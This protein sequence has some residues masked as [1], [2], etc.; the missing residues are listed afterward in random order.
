M[1]TFGS[2]QALDAGTSSLE[3]PDFG[4]V[5]FVHGCGILK[6]KEAAEMMRPS[7]HP[8]HNDHLLGRDNG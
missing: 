7:G 5:T 2:K 8:Y 3:G 1:I 6:V 4:K